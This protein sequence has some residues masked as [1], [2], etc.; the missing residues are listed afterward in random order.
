MHFL[1]VMLGKDGDRSAHWGINEMAHFQWAMVSS[2]KDN[3][4][5]KDIVISP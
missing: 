2:V 4:T 5:K 3:M 1:V